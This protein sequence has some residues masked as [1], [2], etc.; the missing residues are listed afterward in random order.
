MVH[1]IYNFKKEAESKNNIKDEYSYSVEN[2]KPVTTTLKVQNCNGA[3]VF[4]V[5]SDFG[6][7]DRK[8]GFNEVLKKIKDDGIW[9]KLGLL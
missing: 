5:D 9:Q 1:K 6:T 2:I 8:R 4:K 7:E 3:T